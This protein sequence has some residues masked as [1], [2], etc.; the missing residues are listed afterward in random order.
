MIL[1]P[2]ITSYPLPSGCR[3]L[4]VEAPCKGG[5]YKLARVLSLTHLESLRLNKGNVMWYYHDDLNNRLYV[6]DLPECE[7]EI[8][9]T[10]A[11]EEVI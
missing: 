11:Q 1:Y 6:A 10:I 4:Y 9:V 2:T 8:K 5:F 3:V 7:M